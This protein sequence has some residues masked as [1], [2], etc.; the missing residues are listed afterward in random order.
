MFVIYIDI[1]PYYIEE[2]FI[3]EPP[4][5]NQDKGMGSNT[6]TYIFDE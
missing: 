1:N 2:Y 3:K 4:Q 5:G 6:D